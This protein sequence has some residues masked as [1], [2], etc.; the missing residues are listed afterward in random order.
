MLFYIIVNLYALFYT[1][2]F[3]CYFIRVILSFFLLYLLFY[4]CYF[5][6]VMLYLF[7]LVVHRNNTIYICELT[8]CHELNLKLSKEYKLKKYANMHTNLAE[9][10][11][12]TRIDLDTLEV[13]VLGCMSDLSIFINKVCTCSF[14]DI[15]YENVVRNVVNNSFNIYL[16]RNNAS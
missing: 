13:S 12:N 10:H 1:Y 9:S 6:L 3:M 14:P 8:V 4:S 2:Y 7:L 5:I 16:N 11:S 15:V